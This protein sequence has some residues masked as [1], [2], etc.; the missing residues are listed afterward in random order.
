MVEMVDHGIHRDKEWN[1]VFIPWKENI[2]NVV[3]TFN[4]S[5]LQTD[6]GKFLWLQGQPG[7]QAKQV[8][9]WKSV[10]ER[11]EWWGGETVRQRV[12]DWDRTETRDKPE[13][14]ENKDQE[15]KRRQRKR[16]K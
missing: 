4:P 3:H 14:D 5:T 12:R 1:S 6:A 11:K 8:T 7:L 16:R 10:S 2:S 9:Q 13:R 15:G